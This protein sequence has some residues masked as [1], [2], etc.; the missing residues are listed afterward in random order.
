MWVLYCN[1]YF[2]NTYYGRVLYIHFNIARKKEDLERVEGY[3]EV[4]A[5]AYTPVILYLHIPCGTLCNGAS[6]V[7]TDHEGHAL[8]ISPQIAESVSQGGGRE[9]GGKLL[10]Q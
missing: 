9:D 1:V 3:M 2:E 8:C 10:I 7:S 4:V 5:F 6:S